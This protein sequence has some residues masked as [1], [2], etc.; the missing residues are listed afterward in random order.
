MG[1]KKGNGKETTTSS[2]KQGEQQKMMEIKGH[3]VKNGS[4]MYDIDMEV[5]GK[6]KVFLLPSSELV[7]KNID[8]LIAYA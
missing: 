3:M 2:K 5:D 8:R 1:G 7:D 6:R 4:L